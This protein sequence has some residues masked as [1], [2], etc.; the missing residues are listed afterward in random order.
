MGLLTDI[1]TGRPLIDS[2]KDS[3][4]QIADSTGDFLRA[5]A[6]GD[7]IG[8]S[9]D[10]ASISTETMN[11]L[12]I[13]TQNLT[14]DALKRFTQPDVPETDYKDRKVTLADADAPRQ[15]VY[16]RVKTGGVTRYAESSGTNDDTLH[17]ILVFAAHSCKSIDRIYFGDKLAFI[18]T[19][20]QGE[21][22]GK[23]QVIIETGKQT[24]A[25]ASIVS[26]TPSGWTNNHKLLGQTYAYFKLTYDQEVFGSAPQIS[27]VIQGKDDIYDPRTT[28]S[29]YTDNHAL[30]VRDYIKSEYGFNPSGLE[31]DLSVNDD[32][33]ISGANLS[34]ELVVSGAGTTEKR[35]TAN[36]TISVINSP[37]SALENLLLAGSCSL[38]YVQGQFV[39]VSG[40]YIAPFNPSINSNYKFNEN[41]IIGGVSISPTGDIDGRI[42]AVRGSYIDPNQEYEIVDFVQIRSDIYENQD[43]EVLFADTKFQFI[44]TSTRARRV[45]KI[46]MER[47][48]FGSSCSAKFDFRILEFSVGDRIELSLDLLGWS[49]RVFR[50]ESMEIGLD[51]VDCALLGDSELVWGWSESDAIEVTPPPAINLPNPRFVSK[52]QNITASESL[53]FANDKKTIRSRLTLAWD[54][55]LG[56]QR[57]ELS[58]SYQGGSFTVLSDYLTA[59]SYRFDDSQ[60]GEWVFRVRAFNSLNVSSAPSDYPFLSLG[61]TAPPENVAGF[62]GIIKPYSIELSWFPVS[63]ID[64]DSYE[65]RVGENWET[66][67]LLQRLTAV[68]WN[69]ETRPTGTEKVFIKAID[70]TGNYSDVAVIAEIVILPP[71]AV[72]PLTASVIDNNVLLRWVDAT[73]SFAIESYEIRRGDSLDTSTVIGTV[74]STFST[75]FE[76]ES[77]TYRYWVAGIDVQGNIGAYTSII[78]NV[79]QPPDFNLLSNQLLNLS[80][81]TSVNLVN[82]VIPGIT[83]DS[84]EI[85]VDSVEITCD[86]DDQLALIGPA[87]TSESWDEHFRAIPGFVQPLTCDDDSVTC[88]SIVITCDDDYQTIEDLTENYPYYLQP[89]PSSASHEQ[90]IDFLGE[91]KL[92]RIQITPDVEVISGNP[93]IQYTLSYSQDGVSYVD[94]IATEVVGVDFRYVKV[95]ADISSSSGLDVLRINSIRLRLDVKLRTDQGSGSALAGDVGGTQV[96]FNVDFVDVQSIQVTASGTTPITAI[97]D[98]VDIPNPTEFKVLL[99]DASGSRFSG[100]FSWTARGV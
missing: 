37:Q 2:A 65:L 20:A 39:Y 83:C 98:F 59:P 62:S 4:D 35:Y 79:D 70:T 52:P 50:I 87:N 21:F 23:A 31:S 73:V 30:V 42:N 41:D 84:E 47:S 9:E 38:Q 56:V 81:G 76:T 88:D 55:S 100:D 48:R 24:E 61:K 11:V 78:A 60:V 1:V 92:S 25:N 29:G 43:K 67:Q 99:F 46:A 6:R 8:A 89:T 51:G 45:S 54:G 80:L 93:S 28:L 40:E 90:V 14:F 94:E 95:R 91:F 3:V 49:D 97:Y 71:R 66:G 58:G 16:G 72:N 17:L 63:D 64:L 19:T 36:G 75:V 74:K 22:S 85:T 53:Y 10:L 77:N 32:S 26:S 68:S 34:D 5:S 18:G 82:E 15:M 69:W 44:D 86:S 96:N 33:F 7:I 57:W 12:G 13:G 27:A